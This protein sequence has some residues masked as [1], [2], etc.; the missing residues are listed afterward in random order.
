MTQLLL[1]APSTRCSFCGDAFDHEEAENPRTDPND[2]TSICDKCYNQ[3]FEFECIRCAS[4]GDIEDQHRYLVILEECGGFGPGI[5]RINRRPYYT[6]NYFDM[7][8]NK[9]CLSRLRDADGKY[10]NFDEFPSGHLCFGCQC[11][12]NLIEVTR[13]RI[14]WPFT[15]QEEP[16]AR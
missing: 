7:W 8:W 2:G 16:D 5:Y 10:A 1:P 13:P 4:Y 11:E 12:M 3:H 6:S 15:I 9:G 14:V